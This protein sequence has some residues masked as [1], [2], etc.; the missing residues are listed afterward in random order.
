[1]AKAGEPAAAVRVVETKA[2]TKQGPTALDDYL[3]DC[4]PRAGASVPTAA[5]KYIHTLIR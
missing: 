2:P 1:M 5:V 3:F 4:P